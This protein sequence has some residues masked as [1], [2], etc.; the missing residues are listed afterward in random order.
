MI[1]QITEA[2]Q[3][4]GLAGLGG[5]RFAYALRNGT[6]GAGLVGF[7]ERLLCVA[8]GSSIGCNHKTAAV[9]QPAN[10]RPRTQIAPPGVYDGATRLWRV[11]SKHGV[12][13]VAAFDLNEDGVA[14]L[15]SGWS[16][17][18]VGGVRLGGWGADDGRLKQLRWWLRGQV[19]VCGGLH[20]VNQQPR[21]EQINQPT[22]RR[23]RSRPATPPRGRWCTATR[24]AAPWRRCCG[25]TCG[26][27]GS[28]SWWWWGRRGR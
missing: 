9:S 27:P 12:M 2:D 22:N 4:T 10:R 24:W 8:Y 7:W 26:E 17:G 3:I 6:I 23:A 28:R 15:V 11:K 18:R 5:S 19:E 14:E 1:I 25:G 13:A 21:I 20:S 16:N